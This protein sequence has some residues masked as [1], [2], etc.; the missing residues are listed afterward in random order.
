MSEKQ[1]HY[2]EIIRPLREFG[3]M[4]LGLI[5]PEEALDLPAKGSGPMLDRELNPGEVGGVPAN[6][7]S[8]E[9]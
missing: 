6:P 3:G 1:I 4:V 9:G 7:T 8:L 5:V 2:H